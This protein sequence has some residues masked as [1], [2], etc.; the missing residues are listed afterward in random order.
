MAKGDQIYER[1]F[2]F[3]RD[4]AHLLPKLKPC[5]KCGAE[6]QYGDAR[7]VSCLNSKCSFT[8]EI[9]YTRRDSRK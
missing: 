3:H 2:E 9:K 7:F 4:M 1:A 6:L 5:P 8:Q